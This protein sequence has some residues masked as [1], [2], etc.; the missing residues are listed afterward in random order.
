MPAALLLAQPRRGP[1]LEGIDLGPHLPDGRRVE[2]ALQDEETQVVELARLLGGHATEGTGRHG[3]LEGGVQRVRLDLHAW[4]D[5]TRAWGQSTKP[6]PQ[7]G[8]S[9]D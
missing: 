6:P 4:Q 3:P 2:R 5:A 9:H 8:L 7:L 1:F